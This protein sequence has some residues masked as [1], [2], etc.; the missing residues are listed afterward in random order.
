MRLYLKEN[1][2]CLSFSTHTL[3]SEISWT[4]WRIFL[5]FYKCQRRQH[6]EQYHKSD[7]NDNDFCVC[8]T[9]RWRVWMS[10]RPRCRHLPSPRS[11][12]CYL[13]SDV[14]ASTVFLC[15]HESM[16]RVLSCM[17]QCSLTGRQ[18]G[19]VMLLPGSQFISGYHNHIWKLAVVITVHGGPKSQ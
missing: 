2:N 10:L 17:T 15:I 5:T 3:G 19:Q 8:L 7:S 11:V 14:T 13:V 1:K 4:L 6:K 9:L 16:R 12:M 18:E